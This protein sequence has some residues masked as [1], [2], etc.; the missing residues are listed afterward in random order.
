MSLDPPELVA[1]DMLHRLVEADD[2]RQHA[3]F[4]AQFAQGRGLQGLTGFDEAARQGEQTRIRRLG[5]GRQ[6]YLALAEHRQAHGERRLGWI[7]A[8]RKAQG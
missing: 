2:S 8:A 4:L 1:G 3:G 6:Q 7:M 5:A